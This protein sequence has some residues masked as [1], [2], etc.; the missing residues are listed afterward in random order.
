MHQKKFFRLRKIKHHY[1][2]IK[3]A[4]TL[5]NCLIPYSNLWSESNHTPQLAMVGRC[6][7]CCH[8]R[9]F[10][11]SPSNCQFSV[12]HLGV[13]G[14]LV[15]RF[16]ALWHEGWLELLC[17]SHTFVLVLLRK[18]AVEKKRIFVKGSPLTVLIAVISVCQESCSSLRWKIT[19]LQFSWCFCTIF[20]LL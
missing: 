10:H 5:I 14:Q 4:F 3:V 16:K 8:V 19:C 6:C 13:S 18:G 1:F 12:Y 11:K 15:V 17:L 2:V 7:Q 20:S 9:N